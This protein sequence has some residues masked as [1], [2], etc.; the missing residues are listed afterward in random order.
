MV[1]GARLESVLG[2][3]PHEF[4]SRILRHKN[5]IFPSPGVHTGAR[6][7]PENLPPYPGSPAFP[8]P[9]DPSDANT[10]LEFVR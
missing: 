1:Y 7:F 4:E 6:S 8:R 5:H 9:T 10:S 3:S 2:A